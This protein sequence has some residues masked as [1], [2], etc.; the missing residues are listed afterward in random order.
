MYSRAMQEQD[1]HAKAEEADKLTAVLKLE[2]ELESVRDQAAQHEAELR[3][4]LQQVRREKM[5]MEA[6]L[7]GLDLNQME[8]CHLDMQRMCCLHL[9]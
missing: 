9:H 7:G 5:E 6:K 2:S 1:V 3:D 4:E 8:V